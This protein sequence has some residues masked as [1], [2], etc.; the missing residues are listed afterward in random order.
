MLTFTGGGVPVPTAA[1]V[2]HQQR[3]AILERWYSKVCERSR[4]R[5]LPRDSVMNNVPKMLDGL[6]S[7][8]ASDHPFAAVEALSRE[9]N[10]EH[11]RSRVELHYSL[12]ELGEEYNS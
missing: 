3:D 5:E 1:V 12:R 6:L 7:A 4:A 2:L 8:L 11:G 10:D 9:P